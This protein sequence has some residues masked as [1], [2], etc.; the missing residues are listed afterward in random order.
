MQNIADIIEG[1]KQNDPICQEKV[2]KL[3]APKMYAVSLRYAGSREDANDIL[4]DGFIRVFEKVHQF[5]GKGSFEGWIRKIIVNI[6]LGK[7]RKS[8][9]TEIPVE[10]PELVEEEKLEYDIDSSELMKMIQELPPQYKSVFNLYAIDEYSHTDISSMLGIS[11]GTSK[12]NLS[13][14]RAILRI[15]VNEYIK[16]KQKLPQQ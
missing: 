4:Q 15:K 5:S 12:S 1:C 9:K 2:Y 8:F 6:A 13:R 14:A 3:Y 16:R 10:I 7:Y 11:V